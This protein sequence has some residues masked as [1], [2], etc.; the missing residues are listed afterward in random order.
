MGDDST[1]DVSGGA[2]KSKFFGDGF[3]LTDADISKIEGAAQGFNAFSLSLEKNAAQTEL[4]L[5]KMI[6]AMQPDSTMFETIDKYATSIQSSFGLSKER[7]DEFKT[8]IANAAPEL[9][10]LGIE[11]EQ[12]ASTITEA[13]SGLGT[14]ASLNKE[15]ITE[16]AAAN[17][18][19]D[20]SVQSLASGF[21]DVGTSIYDV[22]DEMKKVTEV[23]RAAGVSVQNVSREVVT[24]LGKMNIYNF[25]SGVKGLAK[26]AAT[27]E[28][29]GISMDKVFQIAEDLMSPEKAIDM[30]A[31]LQ[32]LGVTSSGLLDPLRAMDM[33]QND[34]EALQKEMV[35]LSKTFTRFNE[36]TGK[37]EILPGAKRRLREVA[38]AFGYT[39][40]QGA[41]QFAALGIKAADFDMK[42]K[43]IKMP[44]FAG[45]EETKEL[46]ASMAQM[47]DGV[48]KIEIRNKETGITET[49]DVDQ[50]TPEDI[51]NLKKANEDSSKSIEELAFNQLDTTTQILNL[52]KT[53]EVATKF[54]KATSPTL[55]KFYGL[56]AESKMDLAKA[57][58]NIFGSTEKMRQV[59]ESFAKP[60][61]QMLVG[62][63][64][65]NEDQYNKA[66]GDFANNFKNF[67][68]N[69]GTTA[70]SQLE[71]TQNS[72]VERIQKAYSQPLQVEA[73]T[74]SKLT[75]DVNLN[76][77]GALGN[78][79]EEQKIQIRKAIAEDPNFIKNL[80]NQPNLP[81][82][83]TGGKN[84]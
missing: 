43:Q 19:T 13:M 8:T 38:E 52:L 15:A 82:A 47:K 65:G 1:G 50:L 49:K 54:A 71:T 29:L 14:A 58:D 44:D 55:S 45:D 24:N 22:G 25:D 63:A 81:S 78:F 68:E 28:R 34:P 6:K 26:M 33:A 27:S 31:A 10:K 56:V 72:I 37:M 46:I 2:N 76:S 21:R 60:A 11:N 35:E 16:L 77:T 18:L 53:G 39:G 40:A 67:F 64:T 70:V 74:D 80:I 30:S 41:E 3:M 84:D 36:Q 20:V 69:F 48:A 7:V 83:T 57:S 42:L 79:T 62:M 9:A 73:K 12:I 17:K 32:R 4:Y 5:A 75:F 23:A 66:K 61:E 51:E 59:G